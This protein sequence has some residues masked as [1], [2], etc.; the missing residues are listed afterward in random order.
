MRVAGD[1]E[2]GEP[3]RRPPRNSAVDRPA[4]HIRPMQIADDEV[5]DVL[6]ELLGQSLGLAGKHHEE[7]VTLRIDLV[8]LVGSERPWARPCVEL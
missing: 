3:G 6:R 7:R 4:A 5:V 8:S 1:E 2:E